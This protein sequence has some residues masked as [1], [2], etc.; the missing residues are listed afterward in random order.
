MKEI[1][2]FLASVL[3]DLGFEFVY[4]SRHGAYWIDSPFIHFE[5]LEDEKVAYEHAFAV[6]TTGKRSCFLTDPMGIL[7]AVDPLM[8]SA[9][10]GVRGSMLILLFNEG[11]LDVSFLAPF[12]KIPFI[13]E[14]SLKNLR[15]AL[16]FSSEI[17]ERYEIPV[18]LEVNPFGKDLPRYENR[19]KLEKRKAE[20][21][22]DLS[23]WAATPS[24]RYGLHKILNEKLE[25]MEKDFETYEGNTLKVE[26]KIG[27]IL[28]SI[29]HFNDISDDQSRLILSTIHP[30][31][32]NLVSS[33]M[34]KMDEVYLLSG[35]HSAID[36]QI[37]R[38]REKL[39]YINLDDSKR[40]TKKGLG[41]EEEI[42]GYLVLRDTLG[43]SSS[44]NMAHGIRK[45]DPEKRILAVTYEDH[46][47]HSGMQSLIN[48][49]Y[50]DSNYHILICV[51][52]REDEV[53]SF[54]EGLGFK[55]YSKIT[56]LKELENFRDD[57]G[58]RI[59]LYR[60]FV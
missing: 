53:V 47:F 19:L 56:D 23:R 54:I 8:S 9:Y 59:F 41:K 33:F 7:Y 20:F 14:G 51:R 17:S 18:I 10:M 57:M 31:P 26:G 43:P 34:E 39:R 27:F 13:C 6:S 5:V 42:F 37:L 38:F 2:G 60:G 25:R 21:V 32:Q 1:F 24:L 29:S 4:T 58:L 30:L 48:T 12:S 44:I 50:N 15:L 11:N 45:C 22:R 3:E 49:L 28:S 35:P 52:D 16:Q 40:D 36:F 46:F 55:N